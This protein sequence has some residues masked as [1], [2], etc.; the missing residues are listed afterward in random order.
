MFLDTRAS[1]LVFT[2]SLINSFVGHGAGHRIRVSDVAVFHYPAMLNRIPFRNR[3]IITKRI[4][5]THACA[6]SSLLALD[7]ARKFECPPKHGLWSQQNVS[8][9]ASSNPTGGE[10][11]A[12]GTMSYRIVSKDEMLA[13]HRRKVRCCQIEAAALAVAA[14]VALPIARHAL[15]RATASA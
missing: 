10:K 5:F 14:H 12:G 15:A 3:E 6:H 11:G 2:F 7:S 4:R 9:E 1:K 8:S 13:F